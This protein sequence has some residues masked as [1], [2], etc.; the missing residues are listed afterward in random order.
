[1][2]SDA[3]ESSP[4]HIYRVKRAMAQ[5]SSRT[6]TAAIDSPPRLAITSCSACRTYLC[7]SKRSAVVLLL[8]LFTKV[9]LCAL[10]AVVSAGE[11][12]EKRGLL[13]GGGVAIGGIGGYSG[14]GYGGYSGLGYS[15]VSAVGYSAPVVAAAPIVAAPRVVAV[16]QVVSVPKVVSV[17]QVVQV[18]KVVSV[19]Q[20]VTVKKVVAGASYAA[21]AVASYGGYGAGAGIGLVGGGGWW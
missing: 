14:H 9:A 10:V 5:V 13:G 17:P 7:D 1:M 16:N 4:D 15:G 19:P 18:R 2:T 6:R 3:A 21:P 20:V 11:T 8:Y 12:R